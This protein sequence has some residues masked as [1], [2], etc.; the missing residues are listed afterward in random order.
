MKR[1]GIVVA[2]VV[3]VFG[4]SAVAQIPVLKPGSEHQK[5]HVWNGEWIYEGET[6]ATPLGPAEKFSGKMTV[7]MILGGFFQ[8]W[9]IEEKRGSGSLQ[10]IQITAY[11]PVNKDYVCSTYLSDGSSIATTMTVDGNVWDSSSTLIFGTRQYKGRGKDVLSA[12]LMSDTYTTEISIDGKT[13]MPFSE[14]H[15]TKVKTVPK[16]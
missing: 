14:E 13:W 1:I 10:A 2:L 4:V 7:R 3:L 5:L 8:E 6:K 15:I 16:K 12:D 9:R 11:D